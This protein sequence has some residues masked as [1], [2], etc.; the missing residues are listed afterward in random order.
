MENR[1]AYGNSILIERAVDSGQKQSTDLVEK[2]RPMV[3]DLETPGTALIG[4]CEGAFFVSEELGRDQRRWGDS[5]FHQ[6][7][8]GKAE[9]D[10]SDLR[11][12]ARA[13]NSFSCAALNL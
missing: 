6:F 3:R 9:R 4:A 10:L 2:N 7:I 12:I 8:F 1:V 11:R 13:I 5:A